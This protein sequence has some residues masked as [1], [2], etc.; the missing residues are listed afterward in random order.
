MSRYDRTCDSTEEWTFLNH[1][2]AL[3]KKPEKTWLF[4]RD[5]LHAIAVIYFKILRDAGCDYKQ[6]LPSKYF[7]NVLHKAFGMAD[8]ALI[9]RIFSALDKITGNVS[10]K[11][12]INAMSLFLRGSLKL[13]MKYCFR[14]YDITGKGEIRREQMV[15]LMRKFVYKHQDEDTDEAIKDLV[16]IIIKK[17]DLD[18]DGIISYHDYFQTVLNDPMMLECFGQCIPDRKHVYAFMLTFTDKIKSM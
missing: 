15:N 1:H 9:D 4:D 14:V 6:E 13:Q 12:W 18:K 7:R 16:D 8:D 10:L 5:E 2:K 3:L 17:M 11:N